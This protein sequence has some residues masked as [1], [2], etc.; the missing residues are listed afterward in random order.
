MF[1]NLKHGVFIAAEDKAIVALERLAE[2]SA[3]DATWDWEWSG[4][5]LHFRFADQQSAELF[6]M[7]CRLLCYQAEIDKAA[8][9]F[10][11]NLA[12]R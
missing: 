9:H 10:D 4:D 12:W 8:D 3:T 1:W 2:E 5:R 11:P 6:T 7:K